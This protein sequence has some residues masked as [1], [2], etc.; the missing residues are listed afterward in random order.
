MFFP[1]LCI[2]TYVYAVIFVN[3]PSF[4]FVIF[5]ANL[6][7][8]VLFRF[9]LFCF[10]F[11]PCPYYFSLPHGRNGLL[12]NK[13]KCA[14]ILFQT[15]YRS[16]MYVCMNECMYISIHKYIFV[17]LDVCMYTYCKK[18]IWYSWVIFNAQQSNL[19]CSCLKT[20]TNIFYKWL[21]IIK[22]TENLIAINFLYSS[23]IENIKMKNF[24]KFL[25]FLW[26]KK[27]NR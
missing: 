17:C 18:Q 25:L 20:T 14:M 24:L 10:V 5:S 1:Y 11:L 21:K 23:E 22:A 16:I 4:V 9:A 3:F 6:N 13:F 7:T 15:V 19:S 12:T 27:S 2:C 8:C 26:I